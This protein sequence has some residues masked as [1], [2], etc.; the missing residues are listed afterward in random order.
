MLLSESLFCRE[1]HPP[2][3]A[4]L[5][6]SAGEAA[7][8]LGVSPATMRTMIRNG[9]IRTL[10]VGGRVKIPGG[11]LQPLLDQKQGRVTGDLAMAE[12]RALDEFKGN[13]IQ[14]LEDAR[15]QEKLQECVGGKGFRQQ[16]LA[17]LDH[18]EI[19]ARV[20]KIRNR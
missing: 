15:V 11:D 1:A 13:L 19:R 16:L 18:P 9:E 6:L 10:R 12:V 17:A 7:R 5:L 2:S 4:D 8:R 14:A 3:M 20:A